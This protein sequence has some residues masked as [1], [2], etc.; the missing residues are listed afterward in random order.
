MNN[1]AVKPAME[2]MELS[3]TKALWQEMPWALGADMRI[4]QIEKVIQFAAGKVAWFKPP[5]QA[6]AREPSQS[7]PAGGL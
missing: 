1:C 5:P 4:H 6:A 7:Q 2:P 3:L